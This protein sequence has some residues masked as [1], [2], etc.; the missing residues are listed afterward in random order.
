MLDNF[1][2]QIWFFFP[3][4]T[5]QESEIAWN[6]KYTKAKTWLLTT[7]LVNVLNVA[8]WQNSFGFCFC[9]FKLLFS[10]CSLHLLF[11]SLTSR[12]ISIYFLKECSIFRANWAT[13]SWLKMKG[14]ISENDLYCD[15]FW[16]LLL[17]MSRSVG[18]WAN[19]VDFILTME[20]FQKV[21][22]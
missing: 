12:K 21:R 10:F 8:F 19:R 20:I 11:F 15:S 9:F 22:T 7:K 17:K 2:W 18:H 3:K 5:C 16:T 14:H 6:K 1:A 4:L 13:V